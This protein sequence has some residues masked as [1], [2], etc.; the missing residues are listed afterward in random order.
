M[1]KYHFFGG[2]HNY[3]KIIKIKIDCRPG[4]FED[5]LVSPSPM[6]CTQ[7]QC[8]RYH[9]LHQFFIIFLLIFDLPFVWSRDINV[10]NGMNSSLASRSMNRAQ[11]ELLFITVSPSVTI[12]DKIVGQYARKKVYHLS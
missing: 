3:Q 10:Y 1:N 11:K 8:D 5:I 7:A 4:R 2:H 6:R 12:I 9:H